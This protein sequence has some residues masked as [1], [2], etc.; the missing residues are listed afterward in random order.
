MQG[1]A[2]W[3]SPEV[4]QNSERVP[5]QIP[6]WWVRGWSLSSVQKNDFKAFQFPPP[7]P[8]APIF[9]WNPGKVLPNRLRLMTRR[10]I[11]HGPTENTQAGGK[12]GGRWWDWEDHHRPLTCD[13]STPLLLFL[14]IYTNEANLIFSDYLLLPFAAVLLIG[15][16]ILLPLTLMS[17]IWWVKEHA[18]LLK[19]SA[20]FSHRSHL[21]A[22]FVL[23]DVKKERGETLSASWE[24]RLCRNDLVLTLIRFDSQLLL[25]IKADV[26]SYFHE[27]DS[28]LNGRSEMTVLLSHSGNLF[29]KF[30]DAE[31]H[32]QQGL[33][34][35]I[36]FKT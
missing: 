14:K 22:A 36:M 11:T 30:I 13:N 6:F 18:S 25:P 15:I 17:K 21:L 7:P 3:P 1:A 4:Q 24:K 2:W 33:L 10:Q 34:S 20:L 8:P 26:I 29:C 16:A 32:F 5:Q 19:P 12:S 27:F 35:V 28:S 9:Q 31:F 23:Q